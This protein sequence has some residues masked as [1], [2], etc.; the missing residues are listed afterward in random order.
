M[1]IGRVLFSHLSRR[2]MG[3]RS[4]GHLEGSQLTSLEVE[5]YSLQDWKWD[6]VQ[7]C[8]SKT[9][10]SFLKDLGYNPK[11]WYN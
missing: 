5:A 11:G 10:R 4:E 1:P 3:T 9:G 2:D 6:R 7:G 8:R